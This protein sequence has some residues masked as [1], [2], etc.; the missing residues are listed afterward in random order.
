MD[1]EELEESGKYYGIYKGVVA[2]NKD[3]EN[4]GRLQLKVPQICGEETYEYWAFPKGIFAGNGIGAFWIPNDKDM[5]WV[6]FENG[7]PRYPIWE[8]GWWKTGDVP[9]G[10]TPEIKV[11]QST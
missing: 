3:P 8:Y 1:N 9:D 2:N 7:D 6:S 10:A 4:L 11:L 5:V